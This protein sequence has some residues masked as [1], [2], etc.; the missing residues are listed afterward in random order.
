MEIGIFIANDLEYGKSFDALAAAAPRLIN[1]HIAEA[2]R[3]RSETTYEDH[4]AFL[5]V[6]RMPRL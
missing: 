4:V 5:Q 3:G 1:T 2:G 6:L